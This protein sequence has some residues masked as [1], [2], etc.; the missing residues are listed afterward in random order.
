MTHGGT[1][2]PGRNRKGGH[3]NPPPPGARTRFLSRHPHAPF[4]V[5][6]VG[7]GPV[8][9]YRAYSRPCCRASSCPFDARGRLAPRSGRHRRTNASEPSPT[10]PN[11][12]GSALGRVLAPH[13][14]FHDR[15]SCVRGSQCDP[16]SSVA[17]TVNA[18]CLEAEAEPRRCSK[19][20][21]ATPRPTRVFAPKTE[22]RIDGRSGQI[23]K[24][25]P[26]LS[27]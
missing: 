15:L 6:G 18:Q 26:S 9:W 14:V 2:T 13:A 4:D 5:A 1:V 8:L 7:N 21:T 20:L 11:R 10:W 16:R 17:K 19:R 27:S 22:G 23:P 25:T 3:G 12:G 24:A